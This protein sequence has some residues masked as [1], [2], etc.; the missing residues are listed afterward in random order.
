MAYQQSR[1]TKNTVPSTKF[2]P[3]SSTLFPFC[4]FSTEL[5]PLRVA[6]LSAFC[7]REVN[8]PARVLWRICDVAST[9]QSVHNETVLRFF[10]Q[11]DHAL[12]STSALLISLRAPLSG[13]HVTLRDGSVPSLAARFVPPSLYNGKDLERSVGTQDACSGIMQTTNMCQENIYCSTDMRRL[14]TGVRSEKCVVRRF[15]RCANVI[16]CTYTTMILIVYVSTAVFYY[17]R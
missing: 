17:T 7:P 1:S 6:G 12:P 14:T 2:I 3:K 10:Q 9:K 8:I 13:L 15:R 11:V 4:I 16:D 5:Y